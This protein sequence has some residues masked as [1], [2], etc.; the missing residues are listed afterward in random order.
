M[1]RPLKNKLFLLDAMAL[2]YRAY[3]ALN[4]NPRI[5]SKG[6]NTSAILGFANT[7]YDVIKNEKPTH[8]AVAFD[9]VEP[10]ARHE[11]FAAY[12]AHR[13]SMPEEIGL[14][15]PYIQALI[16]AFRIPVLI[17]PGFEADDIIGTVAKKAAIEGFDVYMMT[18]D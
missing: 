13:E 18:P 6:L 17:V 11:E 15:I 1:E 12:K 16:E 5:S 10:T 3:F 7:I 14:S 4:K 9:S 2:I 8:I